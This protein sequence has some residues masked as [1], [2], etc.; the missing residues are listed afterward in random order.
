MH[1]FTI[2]MNTIR[3]IL[4]TIP[5]KDVRFYLVG[6]CFDLDAGRIVVTDGHRMIVCEGPRVAGGGQHIVPRAALE[7]IAKVKRCDTVELTLDPAATA[8]TAF[9]LSAFGTSHIG[10]TVDGRF[11]Q[12]QQVIPKQ[13]TQQVAQY[14]GRYLAEACDALAAFYDIKERNLACRME[15]NGSSPG[16][17]HL[18]RPGCF[19]VIM[20]LRAD[21][22]MDRDMAAFIGCVTDAPTQAAA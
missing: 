9:T 18:N 17:M 19:V 10:A 6:A 22:R 14:N 7:A 15:H 12:Y 21:D 3:A 4:P 11:P 2:P 5:K 20:P 13:F 1:T 16:V 8:P